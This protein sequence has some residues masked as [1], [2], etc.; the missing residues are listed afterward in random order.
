MAT[1]ITKKQKLILNFLENYLAENDSSPS[2]R[3]IAAG[4][5]LSSVASVA[6]HIENLVEKGIIKK[7][8]GAARSLEVLDYQ[9]LDTVE[10]FRSRLIT[11]SPEETRIL[12]KA[13]DI[14]DL[15]LPD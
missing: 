1:K 10:L 4:V 6:E 13:L 9:H 3:E 14:L 8:P 7:T 5:G 11:A 2:Y 12:L 15:E